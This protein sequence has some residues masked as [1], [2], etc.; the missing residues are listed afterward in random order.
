M[1]SSRSTPPKKTARDVLSLALQVEKLHLDD[2]IE[3]HEMT[4]LGQLPTMLVTKMAETTSII[5]PDEARRGSSRVINVAP[6][7]ESAPSSAAS[8]IP[9][10]SSH[11]GGDGLSIPMC[12][13]VRSQAFM[14]TSVIDVCRAVVLVTRLAIELP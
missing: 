12:D 14:R 5:R 4:A 10:S 2:P 8:T 1:C 3:P 7:C 13:Q 9:Q 6:Q 11:H